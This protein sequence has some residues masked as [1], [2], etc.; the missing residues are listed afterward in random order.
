LPMRVDGLLPLPVCVEALNP[1]TEAEFHRLRI[2]TVR[3]ELDESGEMVPFTEDDDPFDEHYGRRSSGF[4][5]S[6]AMTAWSISRIESLMI[7]HAHC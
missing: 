6:D 2:Q 3:Q 1:F 4:M 7:R 5:E